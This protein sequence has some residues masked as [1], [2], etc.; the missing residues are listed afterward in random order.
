VCVCLS[1]SEVLVPDEGPAVLRHG[2]RQRRRGE[3]LKR[4]TVWMFCLISTPKL[5]QEFLRGWRAVEDRAPWRLTIHHA[6]LTPPERDHRYVYL[7][8]YWK[9]FNVCVVTRSLVA[10]HSEND[11]ND[12]VWVEAINRY[13]P[14]CD[15]MPL[16]TWS[17]EAWMKKKILIQLGFVIW[18]NSQKHRID[19]ESML[20]LSL[21][22]SLYPLSLSLYPL[23]LSLF[24]SLPSLSPPLS[25]SLPLSLS[26]SCAL[27]LSLSLP[28]SL[29]PALSLSFSLYPLSL[30]VFYLLSLI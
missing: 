3:A 1:V 26:F 13:Q 14:H 18:F 5:F 9:E 23:S 4:G 11:A 25:L 20:S 2:V 19:Y 29:S 12:S 7:F 24:L 8:V 17:H 22:L 28:I 21:S 30:S 16:V 15:W 10:L 27:S 6:A